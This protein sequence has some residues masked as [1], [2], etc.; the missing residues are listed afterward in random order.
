MPDAD[1]AEIYRFGRFVLDT[2]Q[3]Q[4]R[5]DGAPLDVNGRYFDALALLV[6]EGGKLVSK[7]RFMDEVW[8][9]IPVTDEALTQ[10]VRSLRKQLGD[11]AANPHFIET[12]PRYGYRFIAAVDG[13]PDDAAAT[14][15]KPAPSPLF[16][17]RRIFLLGGA[18]TV[19][20]GLAGLVGGLVYGM[21][22][23]TQPG[24]G[25][26]SALLVILSIAT[27]L[28][29]AGGAGVSFGAA[30]TGT[31]RRQQLHWP[32]IGGAAG[33]LLVGSLAKLVGMDA[34]TLLI[35]QAPT[36]ITGPMEGLVMGGAAG[37]AISLAMRQGRSIPS[38][39][40]IATFAAIGLVA[41]TAI[42][43]TGGRLMLG[44]LDGLAQQFP[45]SRLNM[46]QL[47][48]LFGER[49]F[50]LISRI[51]S[52]GFEAMLFVT[53]VATATALAQRDLN[54]DA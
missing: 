15:G 51:A 26:T 22:G 1:P 14:T 31:I 34:F 2:A 25:A 29:I 42:A 46:G 16:D 39:R 43:I 47:G 48:G 3:R 11:D 28:G 36:D 45:Q 52:T 50:G 24:I 33:G 44:S 19:G 18:G 30:A 5:Q 38:A 10:C 27:L 32:I 6:R 21:I 17:W 49:G 40:T 53:G 9:G 4:L 41:G 7:D 13:A 54:D 37:L 12:V 20:G 23:M 8:R 35:G